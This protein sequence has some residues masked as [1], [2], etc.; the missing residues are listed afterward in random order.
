MEP[1]C[2]RAFLRDNKCVVNFL[3][4]VEISSLHFLLN[5][6]AKLWGSLCY[7]R[8]QTRETLETNVDHLGCTGEKKHSVP[9]LPKHKFFS[10]LFIVIMRCYSLLF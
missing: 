10:P 3:A 7:F 4:K 2:T 6:G 1:G 8:R 5:F 9:Q